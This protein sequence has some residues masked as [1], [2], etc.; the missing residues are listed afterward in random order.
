MYDTVSAQDPVWPA[1]YDPSSF[2]VCCLLSKQ[3][4]LTFFSFVDLF[5]LGRGIKKKGGGDSLAGLPQSLP[6]SDY[7]L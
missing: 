3:G 2:L 4:G 1:H 5:G 6:G 7:Y